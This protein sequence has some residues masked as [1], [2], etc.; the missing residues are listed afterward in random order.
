MDDYIII[1]CPHCKDQV[2]IMRSEIN[3][4]IFRHGVLK[5]TFQ[6]INP[7]AAEEEC[8][9]LFNNNMI[10]GCGKPFKIVNDKAIECDYI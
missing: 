1:D 3:C 6:Q 9:H 8:S 4:A 5:D 7:H 2:L 10:M